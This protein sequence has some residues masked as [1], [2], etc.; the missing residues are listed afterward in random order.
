M[1]ATVLP[2]VS[3][4]FPNPSAI[5]YSTINNIYTYRDNFRVVRYY[6]T[7]VIEYKAIRTNA[8]VESDFHSSLAAALSM[9]S[10]DRAN[11]QILNAPMNHFTLTSYYYQGAAWHFN[12]D[13]VWRGGV[14]AFDNEFAQGINM[15]HAI[16]VEVV[17]NQVTSYRR[18][19]LNFE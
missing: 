13:Y 12:F 8:H 18:L 4:F 1:L 2:F 5:V 11:M 14:V 3:S 19:N 17:N 15:T 6:P 16:E 7:N 9:I 10:R